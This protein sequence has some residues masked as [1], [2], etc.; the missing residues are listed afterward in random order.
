M[1]LV[2]PYNVYA[3]CFFVQNHPIIS[4]KSEIASVDVYFI[5][6]DEFA[7]LPFGSEVKFAFQILADNHY[8]QK[9]QSVFVYL[10][11]LKQ[12]LEKK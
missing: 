3:S 12:L 1:L 11:N 4:C 2:L 8:N 6:F 10:G 5:A 7:Y 9:Q